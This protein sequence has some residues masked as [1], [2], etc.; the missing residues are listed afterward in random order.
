MVHPL[1]KTAG[2]ALGEVWPA[3]ADRFRREVEERLSGADIVISIR[4]SFGLD[5]AISPLA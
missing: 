3:R 5:G 2:V 1:P 4:L